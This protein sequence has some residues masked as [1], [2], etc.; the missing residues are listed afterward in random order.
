[1]IPKY[2]M[3]ET[4]I[5][6]PI[7]LISSPNVGR[8]INV[9]RARCIVIVPEYSQMGFRYLASPTVYI[10]VKTHHTVVAWAGNVCGSWIIYPNIAT[11]QRGMTI[12][13]KNSEAFLRNAIDNAEFTNACSQPS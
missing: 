6:K 1:M 12:S 7:W 9:R 10:A 2:K 11:D 5:I 13:I 3:D 8:L 4:E